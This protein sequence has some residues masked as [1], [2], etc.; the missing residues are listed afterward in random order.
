MTHTE[1]R[2]P[3]RRGATNLLPQTGGT[4]TQLA[5]VQRHGATF[6]RKVWRTS[7]K[8]MKAVRAYQKRNI[9]RK[10]AMTNFKG[11]PEGFE[12]NCRCHLHLLE[13]LY[14]CR[15]ENAECGVEGCFVTY[16]NATTSIRVSYEPREG[17][18]FAL[19]SRLIGG[20]VPEYP[21][22]ICET[23]A[24]NSFYL[25]DLVSLRKPGFQF[26]FRKEAL[27][28]P[29]RVEA[30]L[31]EIATALREH[32]DCVLRGDFRVFEDLAKVVRERQ[33]KLTGDF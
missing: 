9:L 18:I 5:L 30:A 11:I 15:F 14:N 13:D 29:S 4:R 21:I 8:F 28:N 27:I 24:L 17:G 20:K 23:S 22:F 33:R 16:R 31:D 32:A 3:S 2:R 1:L 10:E 6:V 19:L 12:Q 25:D 26:T 7:I